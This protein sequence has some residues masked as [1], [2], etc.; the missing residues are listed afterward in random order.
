MS[1]GNILAGCAILIWIALLWLGRSLIAGVSVR[2]VPGFPSV[3]QI[4]H[5]IITPTIC[6][7]AFC[8]IAIIINIRYND[9]YKLALISLAA[10]AGS[11]VYLVTV[12]GG[13]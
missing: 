5:L 4:D 2:K 6:I 10:I 7:I 8:I 1:I 12:F 11:L 9:T 13:I 3:A